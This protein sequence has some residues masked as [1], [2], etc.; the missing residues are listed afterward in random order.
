MKGIFAPHARPSA[1]FRLFCLP[2]AGG[3]S[4]IY[5][6]WPR[7]LPPSVEL[8]CIDPPGR[9]ERINE[10]PVSSLPIL[11]RQLAA[12]IAP[13]LDRPYGLFGHSN[14]ALTAFELAR[15]LQSSHRPPSLLVASAK[16]APSALRE[17]A[18]LHQMPDP[19]FIAELRRSGATPEEFF[20]CP[21]LI[22][23]FLPLLRA[24]YALSETYSYRTA[25][26]LNADL[27][28]LSGREDDCMKAADREAWAKE[29][30]GTCHWE[31]LPGDHFFIDQVP[32]LV[33][34]AV[35]AA[36]LSLGAWQ[37]TAF[38]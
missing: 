3:S 16:A 22:E 34:S 9:N 14:G 31:E 26:R 23:L 2:Y 10:A 37:S 38:A 17:T 8:V 15:T 28:L 5:L 33:T 19:E 6:D 30:T 4:L 7:R 11:V 36:I 13:W 27:L 25:A 18:A 24:D 29:V 35:A 12:E 20:E 32:D 1:D 21:E